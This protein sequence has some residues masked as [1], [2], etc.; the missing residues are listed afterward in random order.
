MSTLGNSAFD[1]CSSL[2][3]IC[4]PSTIRMIS[5]SSFSHCRKLKTIAFDAGVQLS[6]QALSDLRSKWSVIL[7]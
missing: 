2:E 3:S 4:I 5:K 1:R 7:S 6:A